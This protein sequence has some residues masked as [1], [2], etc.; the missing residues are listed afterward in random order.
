MKFDVKTTKPEAEKVDALVLGIFEGE[1]SLAADVKAVD[2]ALGGVISDVMAGGSFT[3]KGGSQVA[4]PAGGK[5]GAKWLVLVG[6]GKAADWKL[7]NWR[8]MAARVVAAARDLKLKTVGAPLP[9]RGRLE[10][11][12]A[13]LGQALA[14]GALLGSYSYEIYKTERDEPK[15]GVDTYV[16]FAG[17]YDLGD[18]NRGIAD[19]ERIST[20]VCLSRDLVS[21]PAKDLTPTVLA[22]KAKLMA[23]EVGLTCHILTEKEAEELKMGAFLGV[24]KGAMES[25]PPRF[26]VLEYLPNRGEKPLVYVGKGITFDSGGIS[27][28]PADGM[29]KMKYDMAGGAAVI[30]AMRAVASLKLP[31]NVVGL[32]PA[33]ENMPGGHAIHPGDILTAMNGKT[34]EVINT[35][36]EG[37]LIL[38]DALAYAEKYD[39][40]CVVDLA[41]LTGA[42]VIALGHQAIGILGNNQALIDRVSAA[43]ERAW[44]R[45]WQLPLWEEYNDQIK[46]DIADMKNS[47]GR[48][49]GTITAAAM[50][51]KFTAKYAWA[52]LDIAGTAWEEKGR[53]YAPKGATGVGVRLLVELAKDYAA[54]KSAK[55]AA[56][57][58][59]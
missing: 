28:K 38:A 46:S 31:I 33:T 16:V 59:A 9:D 18:L 51:A 26:I 41:T 30:G 49:A 21:A 10:A 20:A 34:I 24:A 54:Q 4:M 1:S 52:H 44:E 7:D 3:G 11:S 36:A 22:D 53:P 40:E 42:C 12:A 14:E 29:E 57:A 45:C 8:Q 27:I 43:G 25:Q 6:L 58:T 55:P 13:D 37:R 50:L 2:D 15:A 56:A 47:G 39:P 23:Q 35:D 17:P 32:V 48:P 5:I 19:G